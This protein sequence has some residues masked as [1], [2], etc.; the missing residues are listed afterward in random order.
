MDFEE[1]F[2]YSLNICPL[3]FRLTP[4]EIHR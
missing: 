3:S 4:L 1:E 2:S